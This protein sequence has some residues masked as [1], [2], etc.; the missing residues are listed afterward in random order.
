MKIAVIG[1]AGVRT[2]IFINGLLARYKALHIDEVALYDI[3]QEKQQIITKLC[4]HVVNRNHK[5]LIVTESAVSRRNPL[6]LLRT[7]L[8]AYMTA[9]GTQ[10]S[11]ATIPVL[12][13][14]QSH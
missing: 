4:R 6:K 12:W 8:P 5:D 11:A 13:M 10:S 2:V 14:K 9:L 1:G 7:M 3:N